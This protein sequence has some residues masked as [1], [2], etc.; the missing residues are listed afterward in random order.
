MDGQ[1]A[2]G[3][4]FEWRDAEAALYCIRSVCKVAPPPAN[5]LLAGLL[6]M[7]PTLPAHPQ[8]SGCRV[9]INTTRSNRP[10]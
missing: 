9:Q 7:L 4:A 6:A 1:V 5:T 3:R 8:V 10:L 2:A